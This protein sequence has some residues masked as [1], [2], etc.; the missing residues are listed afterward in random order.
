M[1]TPYKVSFAFVNTV[2]EIPIDPPKGRLYF[3][4]DTREIM[5]DIGDGLESWAESIVINT[6]LKYS[7]SYTIDLEE[8][9]GRDL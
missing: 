4:D 6:A 1:Y 3:V 7:M 9:E 8:G 5:G 2:E